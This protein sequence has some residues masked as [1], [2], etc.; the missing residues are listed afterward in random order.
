[1]S[2]EN[3]LSWLSLLVSLAPPPCCWTSASESSPLILTLAE[4]LLGRNCAP[5]PPRAMG[6]EWGPRGTAAVAAAVVTVE[7]GAMVMEVR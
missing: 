2:T 7:V 5:L 1:M 3:I 6:S 4:S